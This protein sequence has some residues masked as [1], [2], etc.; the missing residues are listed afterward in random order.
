M[1]GLPPLTVGLEIQQNRNAGW[2]ADYM[3]RCV[4]ENLQEPIASADLKREVLIRKV[5]FAARQLAGLPTF[6]LAPGAYFWSCLGGFVGGTAGGFLKEFKW[7]NPQGLEKQWSDW[8]RCT[9]V[10][11][12]V[13]RRVEKVAE[14]AIALI[15][16]ISSWIF[17]PETGVYSGLML[18]LTY[19]YSIGRYSKHRLLPEKEAVNEPLLKEEGDQSKRESD[20]GAY[21]P[22][23]VVFKV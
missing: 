22:Q 4:R 7:S 9:I 11:K 14:G 3:P 21:K 10:L 23:E 17:V 8:M 13:Y 1:S 5:L 18:G 2:L 15:N 6:F 19:G 12:S 16:F 20:A